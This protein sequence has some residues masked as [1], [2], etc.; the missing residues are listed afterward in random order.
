[1]KMQPPGEVSPNTVFG[2]ANVERKKYDPIY[3]MRIQI[4]EDEVIYVGKLFTFGVNP[5][6]LTVRGICLSTSKKKGSPNLSE[7]D[8]LDRLEKETSVE[9]SF[10]ITAFKRIR[11]IA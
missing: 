10:S 11:K 8:M 1:M 7:K 2:T 6:L 5:N 3:E 9:D 4:G